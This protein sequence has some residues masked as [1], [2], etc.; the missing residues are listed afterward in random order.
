M[1]VY[2]VV[3]QYCRAVILIAEKNKNLTVLEN[4]ARHVRNIFKNIH[5]LF[6]VFTSPRVANEAKKNIVHNIFGKTTKELLNLLYVLVDKNR[7]SFVFNILNSIILFCSQL[8]GI[9]R[10]E[11]ITAVQLSE[12]MY[13]K[14]NDFYKIRNNAQI[15]LI[16]KIDPSIIGGIIVKIGDKMIDFS[17]YSNLMEMKKSLSN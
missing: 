3:Q 9:Q 5:G 13:V 11:V 15:E 8:K 2:E 6:V 12:E 16:R 7:E 17:L 10:V 4:D 1:K 14:I